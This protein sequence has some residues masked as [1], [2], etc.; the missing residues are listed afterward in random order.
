MYFLS[1]NDE[2]EGVFPGSPILPQTAWSPKV[3][4]PACDS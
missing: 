4:R 2:D 1:E 3:D